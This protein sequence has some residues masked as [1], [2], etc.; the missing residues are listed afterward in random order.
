[1]PVHD[2]IKLKDASLLH[3]CGIK[4]GAIVNLV[5]LAPYE[6]YIQGVDG[7]MYTITVPSNEPEV[8]SGNTNIIIN[9]NSLEFDSRDSFL[10]ILIILPFERHLR[11]YLVKKKKNPFVC[12][13]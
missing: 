13:S 11:N 8:G 4:N 1:M 9:H 7:R 2:R 12:L 10:I 3:D 6:I 5:V